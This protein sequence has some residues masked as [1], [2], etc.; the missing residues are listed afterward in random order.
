MSPSDMID[1][2]IN[3]LQ[4]SFDAQRFMFFNFKWFY[5][6]VNHFVVFVE[7]FHNLLETKVKVKDV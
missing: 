6:R 4:E 5:E 1:E 2:I 7:S 3:S